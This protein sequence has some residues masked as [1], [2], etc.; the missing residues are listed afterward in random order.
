[1]QPELI[2]DYECIVGE[3]PLWHPMEKR[4]YWGDILGGKLFRYNP[5]TRHH[6]Q[7]YDGRQVGGFTI[8]S[9]GS[10]LA[11]HGQGVSGRVPRRRP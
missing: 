11:V 1:M 6:E 5:Y 2:A 9:D 7:I 10:L 3:G 4:V 8:Q